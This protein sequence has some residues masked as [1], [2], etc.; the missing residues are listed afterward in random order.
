MRLLRLVENLDRRL[1]SSLKDISEHLKRMHQDFNSALAAIGDERVE[2]ESRYASRIEDIII[3]AKADV[4][5]S[6]LHFSHHLDE[7]EVD[8]QNFKRTLE[9]DI[10]K[11]K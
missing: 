6:Y 5:N 11:S 3:K 8:H 2:S 7:M 9:E 10:N 4:E 1:T